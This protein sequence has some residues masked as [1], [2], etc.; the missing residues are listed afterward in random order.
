MEELVCF[1]PED[2]LVGTLCLPT[3][4]AVRAKPLMALLSN[5]GVIGRAGPNRLNVLLAR[6][7]AAMG[8]P[9]FRFDMSGL[10]DSGNSSSTADAAERWVGDT[11]AAMDFVTGRV[12]SC[13]FFMVGLCSGADIAYLTALKDSRL[14]GAALWD[15]YVYPTPRSR[16][17]ALAYRFSRSGFRGILRNVRRLVGSRVIPSGPSGAVSRPVPPAAQVDFYGRS[18]VPKKAE[19]VDNMNRL[20]ARGFRPYFIYSGSAPDGFNYTGQFR[21]MFGNCSFHARSDYAFL[22]ENDHLL[23]QAHMRERLLRALEA[24]IR[25]TLA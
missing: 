14:L 24:W 9:S 22:Q 2:R 20:V 25:R 12:G 3:S 7:F 17:N 10:G 11:R 23:S 18:E 15:L 13:D 6:R 4:F 21:D 5:S 19:F 16:A 1:G 8:I